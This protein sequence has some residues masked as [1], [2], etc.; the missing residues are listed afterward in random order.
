MCLCLVL[1]ASGKPVAVKR[2][3]RGVHGQFDPDSVRALVHEAYVLGKVRHP[4]I[5]SCYGGCISDTDI[6]IVEDLMDQSLSMFMKSASGP[7]PLDQVLKIGIDIASG[8]FHLHPT[9]IHR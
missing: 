8:L 1:N 3:T 5:V 4:N 2:A 7:L 9:I 6:F